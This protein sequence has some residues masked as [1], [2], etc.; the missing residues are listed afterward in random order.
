MEI[1]TARRL[2]GARW[3]NDQQRAVGAVLRVIDEIGGPPP[4]DKT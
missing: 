1:E 4:Y 2:D 3:K